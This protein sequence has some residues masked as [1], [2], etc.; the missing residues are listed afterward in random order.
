[1]KEVGIVGIE[2]Q[3]A[4][5]AFKAGTEFVKPSP[6]VDRWDQTMSPLPGNQRP[7]TDFLVN[8]SLDNLVFWTY[9]GNRTVFE[10]PSKH[11]PR[12]QKIMEDDRTLLRAGKLPAKQ[13]F[14]GS[15]KKHA[16]THRV[17]L[18]QVERTN[19]RCG[20]TEMRIVVRDFV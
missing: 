16:A 10:P 19:S 2:L 12:L 17:A 5:D 15:V 3:A 4:V 11:L 14:V 7:T 1:M 8:V 20:F 6:Y 18:P 9:I 13:H